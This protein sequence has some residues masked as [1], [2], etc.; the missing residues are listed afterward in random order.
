M[1]GYGSKVLV[2]VPVNVVFGK[3]TLRPRVPV[4]YFVCATPS[5]EPL[6]RALIRFDGSIDSTDGS[7]P[8]RN[9]GVHIFGHLVCMY[10]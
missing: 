4:K 9:V 2:E 6:V 8:G 7:L 1:G 3:A 5:R 10:E